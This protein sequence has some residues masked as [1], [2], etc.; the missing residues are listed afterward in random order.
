MQVLGVSTNA[1][2]KEL[3]V[4][5]ARRLGVHSVANVVEQGE[6]A[7][8]SFAFNQLAHDQVIEVLDGLPLDA[9]LLVLFLFGLERQFDKVL[10]QL[11]VHVV[12]AELLKAVELSARHCQ[13]MYRR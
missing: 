2:V 7:G 3:H 5:I 1:L 4:E 8:R 9:F 6:H 12:D 11:L 13:C 10:L